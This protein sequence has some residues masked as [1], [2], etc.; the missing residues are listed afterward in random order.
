MQSR[1]WNLESGRSSVRWN[2]VAASAG[3]RYEVERAVVDCFAASCRMELV[4]VIEAVEGDIVAARGVVAAVVDGDAAE[5]RLQ[6]GQARES[7]RPFQ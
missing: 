6:A 1:W 3:W 2:M 7:E 4:V 5:V